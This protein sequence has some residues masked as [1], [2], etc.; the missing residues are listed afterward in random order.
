MFSLMAKLIPRQLTERTRMSNRYVRVYKG[1]EGDADVIGFSASATDAP[2]NPAFSS[3]L[4]ERGYTG[5]SL[6]AGWK[7]EDDGS[8]R[9]AYDEPKRIPS[10]GVSLRYV[11][12]KP[13]M[14][15]E[16]IQELGTLC[17]GGFLDGEKI[18]GIVDP[19]HNYTIVIDNRDVGPGGPYGGGKLIVES[20]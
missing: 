8:V 20:A 10:E 7:D 6:T 19:Y 16:H 2:D 11:E 1:P 9:L 4:Q 17:V 18:E 12:V 14:S 13:P 3:F 15:D 5:R